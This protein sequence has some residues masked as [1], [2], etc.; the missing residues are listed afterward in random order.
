MG[1]PFPTALDARRLDAD[2]FWT[3]GDDALAARNYPAAYRL[4]TLAHDLVTDCPELHLEAHRRLKRVT[5]L[6]ADK[7]EFL[8]DWLLIQLAPLKVFELIA[9]FMHGGAPGDAVCRR[10]AAAKS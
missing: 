2:R 10:N 9:Y 3:Q 6:H 5:I 4:Y 8:T 1:A 7:R